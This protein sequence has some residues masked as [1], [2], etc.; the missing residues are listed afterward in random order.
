MIPKESCQTS[1]L[2]H[3]TGPPWKT[4]SQSWSHSLYN[5]D[6]FK[7]AKAYFDH[8][9]R[10]SRANIESALVKDLNKA[11]KYFFWYARNKIALHNEITKVIEGDGIL[12]RNDQESAWVW[13]EFFAPVFQSDDFLPIP[14]I[15]IHVPN[16][17]DQT[18]TAQMVQACLERHSVHT[19]RGPDRI[20]PQLL[21]S[22]APIIAGPLASLLWSKVWK[23]TKFLPTWKL[24]L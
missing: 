20:H 21:K 17:H 15:P 6:D 7:Q 12:K 2:V 8:I 19:S 14:Q 5:S 4:R 18:I 13:G 23:W 24:L 3:C 22:L 9:T 11:P 10:N 16:M 1:S